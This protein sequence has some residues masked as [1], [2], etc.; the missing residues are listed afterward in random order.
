ML[1]A[2]L[3]AR[4]ED[5]RLQETDANANPDAHADADSDAYGDANS[6]VHRDANSDAHDNADSD[7]YDEADSDADAH[8]DSAGKRAGRDNDADAEQLRQCAEIF[9]RRRAPTML[10]SGLGPART[11]LLTGLR[12]ER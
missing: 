4:P 3:V 11:M 5:R 12:A 8:G 1:P 9:R 6:H 2:G 10:R 7:A